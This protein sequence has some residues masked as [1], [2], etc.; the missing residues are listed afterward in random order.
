MS[1]TD[2]IDCRP[3]CAFDQ[4]TWY[5]KGGYYHEGQ[6]SAGLYL[7]AFYWSLQTISTIGYGDEANP[8]NILE[9]GTAIVAMTIGS[10]TWAYIVG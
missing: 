10:V 7:V 8:Y 5:Y 4:E 1:C 3:D 9:R 6:T 2:C